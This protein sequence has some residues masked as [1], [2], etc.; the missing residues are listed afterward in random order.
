MGRISSSRTLAVTLPLLLM[1]L[2]ACASANRRSQPLSDPDFI[3]R[4]EIDESTS[5][6]AYDLILAARPLWLQ[7][8]GLANL[9][10][11]AGEED[12]VVYMDN[13]R[14]GARESLRRVPLASVQYLQFFN[15]REAT[16]RWGGGHLHGAILVSTQRR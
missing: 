1:A 9:R 7:T 13:A 12:I 8:R 4:D 11:A 3:E 5:S 14:L 15:A 6:T 16:L 10:Q 2:S